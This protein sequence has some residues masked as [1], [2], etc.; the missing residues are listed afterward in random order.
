[1]CFGLVLAAGVDS[2]KVSPLLFTQRA[3]RR[4]S[5]SDFSDSQEREPKEL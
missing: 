1:M 2:I 3:T 4:L 5:L